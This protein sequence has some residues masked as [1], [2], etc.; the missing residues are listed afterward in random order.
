[1]KRTQNHAPDNTGTSRHNTDNLSSTRRPLFGRRAKP[2]EKK[3]R[4]H[5][6]VN[7]TFTG[8]VEKQALNWLASRM[9]AWVTPDLLTGLGLAASILIF[10]SYWLT[11]R[12]SRYLWLAS[13]GFVLNWFGDSLDGTIARYRKIE[14]PKYGYFVDHTVDAVSQVLVFL[15]LGLSPYLR[16]EIAAISLIGYLLLSVHV[17]LTTYTAGTFRISYIGLGPTEIRLIAILTNA[18]VF[19]IGRPVLSFLGV[20]FSIY[21]L[22]AV[23]LSLLFY[24]AFIVFSIR[25]ALLLAEI[26]RQTLEAAVPDPANADAGGSR[27]DAGGSRYDAGT[28]EN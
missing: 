23:I 13:F 6:R 8:A 14:R 28:G 1:M 11:T 18:A 2:K 24:G 27:Y 5:K 16:F 19:F 26:D 12:D 3:P 7:E 4:S 9:P 20:A 17:F 21:D 10:I 15:G 22:V 25:Q